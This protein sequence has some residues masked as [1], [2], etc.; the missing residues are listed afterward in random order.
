MERETITDVE[1]VGE[2]IRR[3]RPY[4]E[5]PFILWM[6]GDIEQMLEAEGVSDAVIIFSVEDIMHATPEQ[7]FHVREE[8]YEATKD[9]VASVH[10]EG[11]ETV[12]TLVAVDSPINALTHELEHARKVM[13]L[14][15]D[16]Q[17]QGFIICLIFGVWKGKLIVSGYTNET[18][19]DIGTPFTSYEQA[20]ICSA[21]QVLSFGD[22]FLLEA[23]I[24]K[25]KKEGTW[26][27]HQAEIEVIIKTKQK[28][29][30]AHNVVPISQ[31]EIAQILQA[32]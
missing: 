10:E 8:I 23:E 31:V 18:S 9:L 16:F 5:N 27:R 22:I 26:L 28:L 7:L 19:L 4:R 6:K 32:S 12:S 13:E 3:M 11:I 21:P 30:E 15:P 1:G 20:L 29:T 25:M 24:I 17:F 2:K 14:R